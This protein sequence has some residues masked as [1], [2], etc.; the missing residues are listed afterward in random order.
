MIV[1]RS[2]WLDLNEEINE[3]DDVKMRAA[4]SSD[5]ETNQPMF[6]K[7]RYV[8]ERGVRRRVIEDSRVLDLH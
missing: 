8:K 5:S 2:I 4:I 6:K 3:D 7:R 1:E